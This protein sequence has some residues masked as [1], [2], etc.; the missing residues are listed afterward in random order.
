MAKLNLEKLLAMEDGI[1]TFW[2][3]YAGPFV[4]SVA[5]DPAGIAI[6]CFFHELIVCARPGKCGNGLCP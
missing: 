2:F 3:L 5:K 1:Y 4:S 6:D